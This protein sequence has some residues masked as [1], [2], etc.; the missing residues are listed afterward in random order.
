[1]FKANGIKVI[2]ASADKVATIVFDPSRDS[3]WLTGVLSSKMMSDGQLGVGSKIVKKAEY[4]GKRYEADFEVLEFEEGRL[5]KM[6]TTVPL[7][8]EVVFQINP[9]GDTCEVSMSLISL[10]K[11]PIAMPE[12]IV[13]RALEESISRDLKKLKSIAEKTG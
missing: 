8:F 1:M 9:Q 10:G 13:V 12:F 2:E 4:F 11:L 6:R 3:E 7:E 5:L